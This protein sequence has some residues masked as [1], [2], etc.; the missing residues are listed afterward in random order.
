M[1]LSK[2]L[3][4]DKLSIPDNFQAIPTYKLM[5]KIG[6][7][8]FT[9][10]GI[11][12]FLP[13]G[14]R[15]IQDICQAIRRN[16]TEEGFN[17]VYFPLLERKQ[18]LLDSDIYEPFKYQYIQV[19]FPNQDLVLAATSEEPVLDLGI[20]GLASYRQLPI[21]FLQIADKFRYV[22]RA[23]GIIKGRQFISADFT[24]L[25]RDSESLEESTS[26]FERLVK[27][28][29]SDIGIVPQRVIR[30]RERYVDFVIRTEDGEQT[31]LNGQRASSVAMYHSFLT[32]VAIRPKFV[33]EMGSLESVMTGTYGIGI[34][35]C[36]HAIIES[37]RSN[38]GINFSPLVRPFSHDIIV[39][40]PSDPLQMETAEKV[41]RRLNEQRYR[42]LLDDRFKRTLKQKAE[43]ADFFSIPNKIMV[44]KIEVKNKSLT[45]KDLK[46]EVI[47]ICVADFLS[48]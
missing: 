44:G 19:S 5:E 8:E 4:Q 43:Y 20:R 29:F 14:Q 25:D 23:K 32:P 31:D 18:L 21:R 6:L 35:R 38:Q 37:G 45:I 7:V 9:I 15:I 13:I 40:D 33:N 48:K 41:Y 27:N 11:P 47:S 34:Q 12:T 39:I 42:P 10:P 46:G 24:T 2:Q 1:R 16:A 22:P 36:M 17:E 28:F 26:K 3:F 30:N